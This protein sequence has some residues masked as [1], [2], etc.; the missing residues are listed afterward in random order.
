MFGILSKS[1]SDVASWSPF[2][3]QPGGVSG[4]THV[5]QGSMAQKYA[6]RAIYISLFLAGLGLVA[7][8]A[9]NSIP[10]WIAAILLLAGMS[11]SF[12]GFI[13]YLAATAAPKDHRDLSGHL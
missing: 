13:V 11:G 7:S 2:A 5:R 6:L 9:Y 8:A 12:I 3:V 10:F 4:G 1:H